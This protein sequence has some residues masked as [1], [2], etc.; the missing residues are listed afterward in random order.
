MYVYCPFPDTLDTKLWLMPCFTTSSVIG[1][2]V[3]N[4]DVLI[5]FMIKNYLLIAFRNFW[6]NKV[7]SLI[8][9]SG[10]AIGISASLVIYLIVHHEFSYEKFQTGGDR[11]YRVVTNMHFPEQD[12]KNSGV[13]GPLPEA[14]RNE[15]PGIEKSTVF[16]T[17]NGMKVEI[18]SKIEN[19]NEFKKQGDIV[20]ADNQYFHFFNYQWLGGSP[21][22]SLDGPNKV[23]L[24][25]SRARTYFN[26]PDITMPS[27]KPSF[28][29]IL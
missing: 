16:W 29:T 4:L 10:L 6:R 25:E 11:I 20:Y 15:I 14:V 9:I 18:P 22:N 8:N 2:R 27:G 23:V 17:A 3:E 24:T 5:G 1:T 7:F 13:P 19:K 12:F 26:Y 28:T 21:G